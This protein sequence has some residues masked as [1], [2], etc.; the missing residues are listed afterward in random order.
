MIHMGDITAING[1]EV[2]AVNV[3]IGGSPCQDLSIAGKRAGLEGERSGL[4]MEQL[5]II[6][7][8]R[9]ADADRGRTGKDIRP[10]FMVWE[11]VPGAFSSNKGED[12]GVV[13]QETIK[14]VYEKAP[15]VPKPK[16]GWPT[17]GCLTDM[18]GKWS[19]AWRVL[20]AQFW[21]V[22]Q[23]RRRIAL[24][25]DFGGLSAPEILFERE[26]VQG[27]SETC[28]E[29]WKGSS[30]YAE[31]SV[32]GDDSILAEHRTGGGLTPYT[33]K[34][35]SGCSG[36]GKGALVQTDKSATLSTLQD[37]TLFQ[38]LDVDCRNGALNEVATPLQERMS[39][40][41]NAGG[42]VACMATQQGGAE[43]RTDDMAP[44]LTAAAGMSGN[45]QPVICIQGNCIDRADT[46]G[47][48]GKGWTEDVSYTLN[49]ID[50]P[51]VAVGIPL[52]NDQG[53]SVIQASDN[54]DVSPTLRAEM[55]GNI[56]AVVQSAGFK[57]NQG[58][59]AHGIAYE[60]EKA[61]TLA[62]GQTD[63]SVVI[64]IENHP[65]DS[66]IKLSEDNVV[67]T[68]SGRMG[69]GGGHIQ[70]DNW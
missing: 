30:A 63:A 24:I 57:S 20:D 60:H 70:Y 10:R 11:N 58:A 6:K 42:V 16:N 9:K 7:E 14:V 32:T 43:I 31:T 45:N 66:R 19:L 51:A 8:M 65:N 2:P 56:P 18:G 12:F 55:H 39:N 3:I 61:P 67:Q 38:P 21:G 59:K 25:A 40:S 4:F 23:R 34:I 68:L 62:S 44:T 46:A 15:T 22:P 37:Q 13:L 53:G 54:A 33:L 5:R 64:A 48:N 47:C 36:G 50:R 26:S 49:T 1:A 35:R 69:T 28:R 29:A 17:S 27:Y 52:I 41:L